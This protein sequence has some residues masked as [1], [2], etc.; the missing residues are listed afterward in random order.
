MKVSKNLAVIILSIAILLV[1]I[2]RSMSKYD[3]F[4]QESKSL[5]TSVNTVISKL[6]EEQKRFNLEI[7]PTVYLGNTYNLLYLK[8]QDDIGRILTMKSSNNNEVDFM[9]FYNKEQATIENVDTNSAMLDILPLKTLSIILIDINQTRLKYDMSSILKYEDQFYITAVSD[10]TCT[11]NKKPIIGTLMVGKK[12]SRNMISGFEKDANCKISF[13]SLDDIDSHVKDLILQSKQNFSLIIT[14]EKKNV[15]TAY[16]ALPNAFRGQSTA[17]IKIDKPMDLYMPGIS[18]IKYDLGILTI[19]ILLFA[20]LVFFIIKRY[21]KNA[22][23]HIRVDETFALHQYKYHE[24][25]N[26]IR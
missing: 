1:V 12:I 22:Y 2:N 9:V 13:S 6:Y 21:I 15:L 3:L 11:S 18:I 26:D 10:V 8:S 19:L 4:E 24:Q 23:L 16:I 7:E 20:L 14:E 17:I 5:Y 25:P